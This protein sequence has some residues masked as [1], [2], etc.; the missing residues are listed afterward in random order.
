MDS[1]LG[2]SVRKDVRDFSKRPFLVNL[3][4][5]GKWKK[6]IINHIIEPVNLYLHETYEEDCLTCHPY[7]FLTA[8]PG[9]HDL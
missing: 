9:D 3:R 4:D 6:D 2:M 7:D 8:L 1:T 5:R